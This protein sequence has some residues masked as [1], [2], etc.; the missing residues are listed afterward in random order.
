MARRN[1]VDR[2]RAGDVLLMDG[3]TGVAAFAGRLRALTQAHDVAGGEDG[4]YLQPQPFA[5][6]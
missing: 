3:A 5:G 2:L 4:A 6:V 1:I